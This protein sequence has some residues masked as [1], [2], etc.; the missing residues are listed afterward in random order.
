[1]CGG[2]LAF[3]KYLST[4]RL[5]CTN[6]PSFQFPRP[7]ALP[8]PVQYDCTIIGQ[9]K[10]PPTTS[11]LYAIHHTVLVIPRS[12]KAKWA[13]ATVWEMPYIVCIGEYIYIYIYMYIYI[14]I[15]IYIYIYMS[16]CVCECGWV[17]VG[18][19][20]WVWGGG[21]GGGKDL[22]LD[23]KQEFLLCDVQRVT[24]YFVSL[25]CCVSHAGMCM[26]S[27]RY[28][29]TIPRGATARLPLRICRRRRSRPRRAV[30]R[31]LWGGSHFR[32]TRRSFGLSRVNP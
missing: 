26:L 22:Q 19:W 5:L 21:G 4:S 1:M 28:Q 30:H 18:G 27:C 6:Q 23:D 20:V 12:C 3:A 25:I 14:H 9:Y 8:T 7:P 32:G 16:V 31:W 17:R 10:T 2:G 13:G 15:Y 11:R 29:L 24:L